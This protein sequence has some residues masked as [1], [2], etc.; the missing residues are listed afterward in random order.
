MM[1]PFLTLDNETEIV[2]S[3]I[4]SDERVTA[5]TPQ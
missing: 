1:Y 2:Y 5:L 3:G 4:L